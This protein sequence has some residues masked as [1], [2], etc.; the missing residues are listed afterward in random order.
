MAFKDIIS[1]VSSGLNVAS[2]AASLGSGLVNLFTQ[3]KV[4]KQ[5]QKF[6]REENEKNRAF[7]KSMA[8]LAYDQNL[9]QW[10]R[11]NDYNLPSN[12]VQRLKDAHLNPSLYYGA[13]ASGITSASSP[14]MTAP[15]GGNNAS[16]SSRAVQQLQAVE[17]SYLQ[18]KLVKAQIRN[19]DADT[20]KKGHESDILASDASFRDALNQGELDLKNVNINV[21]NVTVDEKNAN[22]N[23]LRMTF[24]K[25]Q[26]E[27]AMIEDTRDKLRA[28]IENIGA[29]TA[30]KRIEA[31]FRGDLLKAQ[32]DNFAANTAL[33]YAEAKSCLELLSYRILDL[34]A[35]ANVKNASAASENLRAIGLSYE[36]DRLNIDLAIDRGMDHAKGSNG[37]SYDVSFRRKEREAMR[38]SNTTQ[39]IKSAL[40]D[41][42]TA[43]FGGRPN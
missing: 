2:S 25:I 41:L 6:Q 19:I 12:A 23:V 3:N 18:Q 14:Q 16:P 22:V 10:N 24:K 1:N 43:L 7:Q 38:Y 33:S 20:E 37:Q 4:N 31:M 15:Q 42:E 40:M 13:G 11:E 17:D 21:G 35:S 36:N 39:S 32:I 8:Q 27:C 28:E 30:I 29:D 5:N 9:A 34:E 26:G